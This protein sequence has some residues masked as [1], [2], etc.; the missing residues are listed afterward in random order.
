MGDPTPAREQQGGG[1]KG[2]EQGFGVAGSLLGQQSR[3]YMTR[4]S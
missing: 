2:V 1:G 4:H 3:N